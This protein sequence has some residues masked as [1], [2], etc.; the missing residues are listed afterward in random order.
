M[1]PIAHITLHALTLQIYLPF[2]TSCRS[3][4]APA[5]LLRVPEQ[6]PICMAHLQVFPPHF[7]SARNQLLPSFRTKPRL[8]HTAWEIVSV[9]GAKVSPLPCRMGRD[10]ALSTPPILTL[11][12]MQREHRHD[13]ARAAARPL[14]AFPCLIP[15]LQCCEVVLGYTQIHK[16]KVKRICFFCLIEK[17]LETWPSCHFSLH[18]ARRWEPY[19]SYLTRGQDRNF[20]AKCKA[21]V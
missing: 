10:Q 16:N 3:Q 20:T 4:N 15:Q 17:L 14:A 2:A 21:N 19:L 6:T 5:K 9:W 8:Q 11:F 13:H 1:K 18:L 7:L 12:H